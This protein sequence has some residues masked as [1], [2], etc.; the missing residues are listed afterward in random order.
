[1]R[2]E[3]SL[4]IKK[5]RAG[6]TGLSEAQM[7]AFFW[8]VRASP[9]DVLLAQHTARKAARAPVDPTID[10]VTKLMKPLEVRAEDKAKLLASAAVRIGV[11]NFKAK[12]ISDAV[13]KLKGSLTDRQII[14]M[15]ARIVGEL[16]ANNRPEHRIA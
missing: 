5:L 4:A 6:R 7:K 3:T 1:M 8:E 15:S 9:D 2:L 14:E 12:G 16:D 11:P 10:A 13:R